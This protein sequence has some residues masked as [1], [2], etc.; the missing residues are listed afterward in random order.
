METAAVLRNLPFVRVLVE[1]NQDIRGVAPLDL[2]SGPECR[3]R[4]TCLVGIEKDDVVLDL[5]VDGVDGGGRPVDGQVAGHRQV[6]G[7]RAASLVQLAV[8]G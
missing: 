2:D 8:P 7:Y 5:Q 6:T 3:R 4:N 1:P